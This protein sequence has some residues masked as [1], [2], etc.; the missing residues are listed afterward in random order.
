[1]NGKF[2]S[3]ITFSGNVQG[4]GFRRRTERIAARYPVGGY[5]KN[6]PDGSVELYIEGQEGDC[7]RFLDHVKREMCQEISAVITKV[8]AVLGRA[9][10][11]IET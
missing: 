1:L 3:I 11:S 9:T 10:F 6:L 8:V 2:A 4:V 5:V 7:Q